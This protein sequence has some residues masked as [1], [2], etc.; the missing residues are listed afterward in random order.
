MINHDGSKRVMRKNEPVSYLKKSQFLTWE[1]ITTL[2]RIYSGV[3][4]RVL[5]RKDKK[6]DGGNPFHQSYIFLY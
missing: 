6:Q 1:K 5:N 2:V 4:E 3:S